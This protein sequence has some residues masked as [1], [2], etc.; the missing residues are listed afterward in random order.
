M[1]LLKNKFLGSPVKNLNLYQIQDK[2]A[3]YYKDNRN[4]FCAWHENIDSDHY[5]DF[6]SNLDLSL[7]ENK[8][9]YG[10]V[11]LL[12]LDEGFDFKQEFSSWLYAKI[13]PILREHNI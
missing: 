10:Q 6:K 7:K 11:L 8:Q 1:T 9:T 3:L 2:I 4:S 13:T 5:F 12:C